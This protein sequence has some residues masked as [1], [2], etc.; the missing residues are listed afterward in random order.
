MEC[1]VLQARRP[2]ARPEQKHG[3]EKSLDKTTLLELCKPALDHG[4]KVKATLPIIN[5]NRVVGTQ[6]VNILAGY[7]AA[8]AD[9][10]T[11]RIPELWDGRTAERVR[12]VLTA[13]LLG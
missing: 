3:L 7:R 11:P 5:T 9:R 13:A 12:D 2:R 6:P 4:V 8:L 10:G 1:A